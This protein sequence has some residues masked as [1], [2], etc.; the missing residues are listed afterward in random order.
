M[1]NRYESIAMSAALLNTSQIGALLGV[2]QSYVS[3]Q[4]LAGRFGAPVIAKGKRRRLYALRA[5]ERAT[6]KKFSATQVAAAKR[7]KARIKEAHEPLSSAQSIATVRLVE[8]CVRLR[9]F[10]WQDHLAKHGVTYP[11]FKPPTHMR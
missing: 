1:L 3:R 6:G 2:D 10:D 7:A 4:A 8:A 5:I 11:P 9:D